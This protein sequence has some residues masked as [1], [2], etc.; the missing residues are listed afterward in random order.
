[1]V[2]LIGKIKNSSEL[3]RTINE[4]LKM[5]IKEKNVTFIFFRDPTGEERLNV[6]FEPGE[7]R[8]AARTFEEG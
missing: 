7:L 2:K 1:M 4:I 5:L 8:D 6:K 3:I